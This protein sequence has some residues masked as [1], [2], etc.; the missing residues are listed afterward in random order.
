M[1]TST[2]AARRSTSGSPPRAVPDEAH[3]RLERRRLPHDDAHAGV[4]TVG[5]GS[6]ASPSSTRAGSCAWPRSAGAD[7]GPACYGWG[8]TEPH[9]ARRAV[10]L[11]RIRP[12]ALLAG[13]LPLKPELAEQA[14][15]WHVSD[16]LKM[17]LRRPRWACSRSR[18][19][20]PRR[21]SRSAA[22]A[23]ARPAHFGLVVLRRRR[24]L[25]LR[26]RL[27]SEHA[28]GGRPAQPGMTWAPRLLWSRHRLGT[29]ARC[30]G[31]DQDATARFWR[32]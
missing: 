23:R 30:A 17:S 8:G 22:C 4:E 13:S 31:R 24:A 29:A 25:L 2:S 28:E 21:P 20:P 9:V 18:P 32:R 16:P 14:V 11:G 10:V 27:T 1:I 19:R 7:P 26:D 3:P 12:D 15:R 5:T 6:A